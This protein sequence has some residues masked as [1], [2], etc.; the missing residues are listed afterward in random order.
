MSWKPS[1]VPPHKRYLLAQQILPQIIL[2]MR[3]YFVRKYDTPPVLTSLISDE[4]IAD[5]LDNDTEKDIVAKFLWYQERT[6]NS[7]YDFCTLKK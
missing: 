3:A 1:V 2:D 5:I 7:F 6:W 4:D